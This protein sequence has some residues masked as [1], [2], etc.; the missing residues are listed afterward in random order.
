MEKN[1]FSKHEFEVLSDKDFFYTK[2]AVNEKLIALLEVTQRKISEYISSSGFPFPEEC[3]R[4]KGKISKGENYN[5]LPWF[6]LDYPAFFTQKD[7]FAFRTM[8]WWGECF[9]CTFLMSG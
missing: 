1:Y 9:S 8:F 2:R 5:M 3:H 4:K 6:M 7:I